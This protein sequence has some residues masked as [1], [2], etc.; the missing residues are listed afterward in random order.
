MNSLSNIMFC[1]FVEICT[2]G[3]SFELGP[4]FYS[5]KDLEMI[6]SL[7][8]TSN[9]FTLNKVSKLFSKVKALLLFI[10]SDGDF[11]FNFGLESCISSRI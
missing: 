11:K 4:I 7:K 1:Y 6:V 10:W 5:G 8:K 3:S 9:V 2:P